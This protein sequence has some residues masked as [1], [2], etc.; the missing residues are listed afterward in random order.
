ML[1]LYQS[2]Q[3]IK[4]PTS[5]NGIILDEAHRPVDEI[6]NFTK[7]NIFVGPNNTG[8]SFLLRE[9]L[10][11]QHSKKYSD[12]N[13]ATIRKIILDFWD[14]ATAS[15]QKL[16]PEATYPVFGNT[17]QGE[18]FNTKAIQE[19]INS[20]VIEVDDY[21]IPV[22]IGIIG[23]FIERDFSLQQNC[24]Y[25]TTDARE[26]SVRRNFEKMH[27]DSLVMPIIECLNSI[28]ELWRETKERL[29]AFTFY[30][31]PNDKIAK[32]Y[33]P[34]VRT[35][36]S[37]AKSSGLA[38]ITKT[39]YSF[40][41]NIQV[42]NG[43]LLPEEIFRLKNNERS[44]RNTIKR[45]E[46]FLSQN[47]FQSEV[48]ELTFH[49]EKKV[50]YIR[51]GDEKDRPIFELGDGLQ[52]IIIM[53][54]PFFINTCG[55]VVI[56]EPEI[57]IHPGL[58]KKLMS[59]LTSH[60]LTQQFQVNIATHS[61]HILDA[62]NLSSQVSIFGIKKAFK[63]TAE[64][65]EKNAS[66]VI[67]PL[68][69]GNQTI[70][71]LLGITTTSVYLSNCIIWVEGVTDRIY[72]Q[73]FITEY[74]KKPDLKN[75]Y[76]K[77]KEYIEGIHYSFAFTGGDSIIHWDFDEEAEYV[78]KMTSVIVRK[79]CAKSIVIVDND[80]GKNTVRKT[81]LKAILRDRLIILDLPEIENFLDQATIEET[82]L[83]Y[84]SVKLNYAKE[85]FP[86]LDKTI[87]KEHRIGHVIDKL[88]LHKDC[89]CKKF[90]D[91]YS[92][93]GSLKA[94]DKT[95]FAQ[96]AVCHLHHEKLT[97][98]ACILTEKILELILENNT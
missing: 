8:K 52:M 39:E 95:S 55:F 92:K 77:C 45:F 16:I 69:S 79:F 50:L 70:L 26:N 25:Y 19:K 46:E 62:L 44:I 71:N 81:Q 82:I 86:L 24:T 42:F 56:E 29:S 9:I 60:P 48:V 23:E 88:L 76:H 51:V 53:T 67:E 85:D 13:W 22:R 31:V 17:A 30:S 80:F 3:K 73:K 61:N 68:A 90:S 66:Y 84:D 89:K 54:F 64:Q 36:R 63:D 10:K 65:L 74:L 87:F 15:L 57:Y 72:L 40:N 28:K 33:I 41:E 6:N 1:Q 93:R 14:L 11:G 58:Q 2:Y 5:L 96:E 59:F 37:F 21:E 49:H 83:S 7:V 27:T 12:K 78:E 34:A 98:D 75:H 32:I 38:H 43:E 47:F 94:G 91:R 35:L 4:V 97:D 20:S 18:V